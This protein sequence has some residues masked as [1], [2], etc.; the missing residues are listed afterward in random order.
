VSKYCLVALFLFA[1][2]GCDLA[3]VFNDRSCG[4]IVDDV[5]DEGVEGI[6]VAITERPGPGPS[7]SIA[8]TV[9]KPDGSYCVSGST[10]H[11]PGLVGLEVNTEIE[12]SKAPYN[13]KYSNMYLR[14][15][16]SANKTLRLPRNNLPFTSR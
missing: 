2:S 4:R 7:L 5:T 14:F 9:T 11:D 13:P 15:N 16:K 12:G 3:N 8:A 10:D 6:G 1:L